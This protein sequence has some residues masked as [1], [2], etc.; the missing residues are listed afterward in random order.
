MSL[1]VASSVVKR[2]LME[3]MVR[4]VLVVRGVRRS[5]EKR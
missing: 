4:R 3:V 1:F 2:V 5:D